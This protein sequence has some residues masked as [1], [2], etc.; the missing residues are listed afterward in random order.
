MSDFT[1]FKPTTRLPRD[2]MAHLYVMLKCSSKCSNNKQLRNSVDKET[3]V[4]WILINHSVSAFNDNKAF[5]LHEIP[6]TSVLVQRLVGGGPHPREKR[7]TETMI[8]TLLWDL[9]KTDKAPPPPKK[10]ILS[11]PEQWMWRRGRAAVEK[12]VISTAEGEQKATWFWGEEKRGGRMEMW[13]QRGISERPTQRGW[14]GLCCSAEIEQTCL[15]SADADYNSFLWAVKTGH[16]GSGFWFLT[17][18]QTVCTQS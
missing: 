10:N 3:K 15:L 9:C 13:D 2:W 11:F 18:P 7:P 17:C 1:G 8:T 16:E 4:K 14:G 6:L 5:L 12:R